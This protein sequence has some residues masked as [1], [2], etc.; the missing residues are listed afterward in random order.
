MKVQYCLIVLALFF[1]VINLFACTS[2][3]NKSGTG[4][5]DDGG[6]STDDDSGDDDSAD[7]ILPKPCADIY[8]QDILPTFEVEMTQDDW[9]AL[10]YE[11]EHWQDLE[12][13]GK[14]IKNYYPIT[15]FRYKDEAIKNAM[16]RLRGY[17]P[18]WTSSKMQFNVSFK[19]INSE[20][21]FH[22]LRQIDL[23]AADNDP[24]ILRNRLGFSIF[25]DI[26]IPAS[27]VNNAKLV[28]NGE[29]YGLYA[30]LEH[31]D[32]EFL[33][34]NFGKKDDDGNLYKF[35]A[36]KTNED[37]GDTSDLDQFQ[38]AKDL[39]DLDKILDLDESVL[40]WAGEAV[41]PH[42]DGF[43]VGGANYYL[44]HHPTRGFLFFPYDIDYAFEAGDFNADPITY[45]VP[46]GFGKPAQFTI[47]V[48]DP[49]WF[50]K[51]LD[52]LEFV[53]AAY[54]T[55]TV[56]NRIDE[57]AAQISDAVSEDPNRPF[58]FDDHNNEVQKLRNFIGDRA[59]F[60]QTWINC[61][62][63]A[64][65][66]ETVQYGGKQYYF[67]HSICSWDDAL[68]HC[69]Y[70]GGTLAVPTNE[71]EQNFVANKANEILV[72]NWWTGANDIGHE[73]TWTTPDN[74]SLTYLPWGTGQPDGDN[75]QNCVALDKDLNW[76]WNDLA[77]SEYY[78]S[79]CELP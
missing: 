71:L 6:H 43:W 62:K 9:N 42:I 27:C 38:S 65:D 11:F 63:H 8:A 57:W 77:C 41:M 74:I 17:P 22:G 68:N 35:E 26:R 69:K 56:L 36:L 10:V 76:L 5:D 70:L 7:N 15:T 79:V 72:N 66:S 4:S 29:Y 12:N 21:R 33:Q 19:E 67:W 75:T 16:I 18:G 23:S 59:Y 58:S 2:D 20:L 34:R 40:E 51:Y 78:T 73:G 52:D 54:N 53:L 24:T 49:G 50:Q 44:Y 46:W 31:I 60:V 55:D 30:N 61:K 37:V 28:I 47:V 1:L 64:G 32:K 25:Q 13:Q 3:D 14:P 45:T 39:A 48:S